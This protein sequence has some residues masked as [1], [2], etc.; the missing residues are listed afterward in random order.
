MLFADL[1][2]ETFSAIFANKARSGLTI[3]GI[4]I[5]IGS[6]IAMISV[7]QGAQGQIQ[8]S[9][10][11][12]GSN[13]LM[14]IPGGQMERMV[15]TRKG[16][17]QTLTQE[18]ADVIQEE[19]TLIE[20]VAPEISGYHQIIAKGVNTNTNV[21]GTVASYIQVRNLE[22]DIGSFISDQNVKRLSKIAVL[23]PAARDDLFGENTNPIGQKVRIKRIDFTVVGMTK[24]KGATG[25]GSQDDIIF[26]PI[27]TAQHFLSGSEYVNMISVQVQDQDSMTIAQQQITNLLLARHNISDPLLA[28]FSVLNQADIIETASSITNTFTALLAAIAAISLVVG[29]IGIMNM[30]LTTVT[31]RTREIGLRKALGAKNKEISLQFLTEAIILTFI[32]GV[33]GV[34][35]GWLI[36]FGITQLAGIVT[37]V[38]LPSIILAFGVSAAIGIIFGYYPARRAALLNPIEALRYE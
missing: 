12:M 26:I 17:A 35:L 4:V 2:E 34:I 3:L 6:V 32:G 28:D 31:E 11:S 1:L 13:L 37:S 36:S 14:V 23:G 22:I 21:I 16:M 27:S 33:L 7:G 24:P 8:S 30:M 15:K 29:G 25:F 9:I 20:T 5:G 19:I 10:E 38:S 18:D